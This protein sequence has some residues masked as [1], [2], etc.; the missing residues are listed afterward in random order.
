MKRVLVVF[1]LLITGCDTGV[2]LLGQ[3]ESP[4]KAGIYTGD[5]TLT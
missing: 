2:G 5:L 3:N 4:L 1:T